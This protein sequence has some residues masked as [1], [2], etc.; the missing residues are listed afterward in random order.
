MIICP[1]II[2]MLYA[3]MIS[4]LV[5]IV[6]KHS[7][8]SRKTCTCAWM[9]IHVISFLLLPYSC[10]MQALCLKTVDTLF[11]G[12]QLIIDLECMPYF[13]K[14][15]RYLSP[16]YNFGRNNSYHISRKEQF[17]F[18]LRSFCFFSNICWE[19]NRSSLFRKKNDGKILKDIPSEKY[20]KCGI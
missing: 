19:S 20:K 11:W 18:K 10:V 5:R 15:I 9:G 17:N 16:T 12:S 13:K 6:S 2:L 7:T 3:P 4:S 1:S 8:M 14:H